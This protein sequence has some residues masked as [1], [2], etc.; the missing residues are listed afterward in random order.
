MLDTRR[1]AGIPKG[2][3]RFLRFPR[4]EEALAT[5]APLRPDLAGPSNPAS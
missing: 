1:H 3:M 2:R 5:L 4:I